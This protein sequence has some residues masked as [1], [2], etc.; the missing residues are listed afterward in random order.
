MITRVEATDEDV[1]PN[2]VIQFL[3]VDGPVMENFK[4]QP[5]TGEIILQRQLTKRDQVIN[6]SSNSKLTCPQVL[7]I[8]LMSEREICT[9]NSFEFTLSDWIFSV[10]A[11]I[12]NVFPLKVP[13]NAP[14]VK[15]CRL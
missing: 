15:E 13:V 9:E 10:I 1:G 6:K 8:C 14:I 4:I 7:L 2:A 12:I 3:L 5:K 11:N